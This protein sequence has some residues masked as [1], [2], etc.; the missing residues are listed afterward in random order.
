LSFFG[1]RQLFTES[2][3]PASC[4]EFSF[5]LPV[6]E[7]RS[8]S[9][10]RFP[11]FGAAIRLLGFGASDFARLL[12]SNRCVFSAHIIIELVVHGSGFM[13]VLLIALKEEE[14]ARL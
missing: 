11:S 10:L 2:E 14:I 13:L 1:K 7:Y 8:L 4:G 6:A 3:I 12:N 5:A 9:P